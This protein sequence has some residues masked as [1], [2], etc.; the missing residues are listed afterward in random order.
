VAG[1][2][3]TWRGVPAP[4]DKTG[5]VVELLEVKDMS[6]SFGGV[7]A[8]DGVTLNVTRGQLVGLIGANGAG[9]TTFIDA[10]T[11]FVPSTG[12][13]WL[14]GQEISGFPNYQRVRA[15]LARTWQSSELFDDLTVAENLRVAAESVPA[16]RGRKGLRFSRRTKTPDHIG[17]T[18]EL[19]ELEKF[20]DKLPTELSHGQRKLVGVAR[21]LSS[22]PELVLLDEPAAGLDSSESGELGNRLKSIVKSGTTV[23]MIDH[24][25]G[26]VLTVCDYIY[27]LEFGQLLA[28]G[29]PAEIR[30]NEAVIAAYL[31]EQS[32]EATDAAGDAPPAA[33]GASLPQVDR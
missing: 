15:G 3:R 11:G 21:A 12:R 18:L 32:K 29:T 30:R 33:V 24:D 22:D 28:K 1:N 23:F 31:G 16:E 4:S 20:A 19:L 13:V 10:M 7:R 5:A 27:M 6:V 25:M 17:E 9:K 8:V 14:N 2:V 26:L